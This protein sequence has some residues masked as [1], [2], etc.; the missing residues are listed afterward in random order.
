MYSVS[1]RHRNAKQRSGPIDFVK[2]HEMIAVYVTVCELTKLI[3]YVF[4]FADAKFTQFS[5]LLTISHYN[6]N[7]KL[8]DCVAT[9][10][11]KI[12]DS[13]LKAERCV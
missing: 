9:L 13:E 12:G 11:M 1:S 8:A 6:V 10:Y 4:L 2:F 3:L 7:V 5:Q